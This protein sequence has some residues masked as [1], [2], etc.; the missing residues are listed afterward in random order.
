MLQSILLHQVEYRVD[1]PGAAMIGNI[2]G[3]PRPPFGLEQIGKVE[4][5]C[6]LSLVLLLPQFGDGRK[7]ATMSG[8]PWPKYIGKGFPLLT[9]GI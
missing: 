7:K 5:M 6:R 2:A 3:L 8:L 4:R 1:T 9:C